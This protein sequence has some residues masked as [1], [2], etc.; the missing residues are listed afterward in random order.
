MRSGGGGEN[1]WEERKGRKVRPI[2]SAMKGFE[3]L[4]QPTGA[5]D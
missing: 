4:C 5:A 2:T 1:P 3:F